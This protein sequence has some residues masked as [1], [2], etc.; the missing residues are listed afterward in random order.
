MATLLQNKNY[1]ASAA[2]IRNVDT[3]LTIDVSN[4]K[5]E[6]SPN[7]KR[8]NEMVVS[9]AGLES[10]GDFTTMGQEAACKLIFTQSRAMTDIEELIFL[11]ALESK[12]MVVPYEE[13][14]YVGSPGQNYNATDLC[15][16]I[17]AAAAAVGDALAEYGNGVLVDTCNFSSY[18]AATQRTATI[19]REAY[20]ASGPVTADNIMQGADVALRVSETLVDRRIKVSGSMSVAVTTLSDQFTGF[21]EITAKAIRAGDNSLGIFKTSAFAPDGQASWAPDGDTLEING[22]L[23]FNGFDGCA[24]PYQ[25]IKLPQTVRCLG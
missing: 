22:T 16:E 10:P 6:V 11:L 1:R 13:E 19:V 23:F 8:R 20:A 7:I 15:Y 4:F 18:D 2:S 14:I 5:I 24:A 17:P 21:Y 25:F 12:T 3:G 9:G